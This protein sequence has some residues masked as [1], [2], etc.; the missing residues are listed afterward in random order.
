MRPWV[1][2]YSCRRGPSANTTRKQGPLLRPRPRERTP[3]ARPPPR[4]GKRLTLRRWR[5]GSNGPPAANRCTAS[6]PAR[7]ARRPARGWP[8]PPA[9][10]P[11]DRARLASFQPSPARSA[12]WERAARWWARAAGLPRPRLAAAARDTQ[13][14]VDHPVVGA[15]TQAHTTAGR[16]LGPGAREGSLSDGPAARTPPKL[17]RR[18]PQP[19]RLRA[20]AARPGGTEGSPPTARQQ[21]PQSLSRF[22][23]REPERQGLPHGGGRASA[24]A[25]RRRGQEESAR[26]GEP[27]RRGR[28]PEPS[29]T[30]ARRPPARSRRWPPYSSSAG[31]QPPRRARARPRPPAREKRPSGRRIPAGPASLRRRPRPVRAA[32]KGKPEPAPARGKTRPRGRLTGRSSPAAA[33]AQ[34]AGPD[35]GERG[36]G[37]P[38]RQTGEWAGAPA[39]A[40]RRRRRGSP[41]R[42]A[43]EAVAQALSTTAPRAHNP[44]S[45]PRLNGS[46]G[47]PPPAQARAAAGGRTRVGDARPRRRTQQAKAALGSGGR[48]PQ[49][50]R[51]PAATRG[52]APTASPY[53]WRRRPAANTT[54]DRAFHP[55][56]RSGSLAG[57]R[58]TARRG[59]RD[60]GCLGGG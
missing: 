30:R 56:G 24:P 60:V 54:R 52:P 18:G 6:C 20:G 8:A 15:A 1:S 28:G 36:K 35:E 47:R 29:S 23:G 42:E 19:T 34:R 7:H 26:R 33:S 46:L 2:P 37:S 5:A 17:F 14:K 44:L 51:Q 31:P 43:T 3:S 22:R 55:S 10:A 11:R 21:A 27:N 16:A 4:P 9:P 39:G 45:T 50:A 13:M 58:G 48:A 38:S 57:A 59:G 25:E 49:P 12:G 32:A 41:C 53:S 40:A